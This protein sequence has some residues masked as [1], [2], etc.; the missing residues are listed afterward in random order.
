MVDAAW[1]AAER[2]ISVAF[3]SYSPARTPEPTVDS[4][5][6]SRRIRALLRALRTN[7][8]FADSCYGPVDSFVAA[9]VGSAPLRQWLLMNLQGLPRPEL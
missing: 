6:L 5:D 1:K 9:A 2:G 3:G 4:H 7:R 8:S